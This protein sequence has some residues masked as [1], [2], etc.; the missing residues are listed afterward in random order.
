MQKY[1]DN[2]FTTLYEDKVLGPGD[3]HEAFASLDK[4]GN[5]IYH[6]HQYYG[7]T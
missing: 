5:F 2:D 7:E 4:N 6:W 3:T 1:H